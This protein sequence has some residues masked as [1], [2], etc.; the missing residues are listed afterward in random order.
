MSGKK[1]K[2][3]DHDDDA[4]NGRSCVLLFSEDSPHLKNSQ[5]KRKNGGQKYVLVPD[6]HMN[7]SHDTCRVY[8]ESYS[9]IQNHETSDDFVL[10]PSLLGTLF[11]DKFA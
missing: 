9:K 11:G 10:T 3:N 1:T 6:E 4:F 8:N 2:K 7:E 5:K